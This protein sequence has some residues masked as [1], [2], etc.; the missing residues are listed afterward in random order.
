MCPRSQNSVFSGPNTKTVSFPGPNT[1]TVSFTVLGPKNSVI[2]CPG[3]QNSV[4]SWSHTPKQFLLLVPHTK[5]VSLLVQVPKQ[6]YYWCTDTL[7]VPEGTGCPCGILVGPEGPGCLINPDW[8]LAHPARHVWYARK[9]KPCLSGP[10]RFNTVSCKTV[11]SAD[12][13]VL[14]CVLP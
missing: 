9:C 4:F 1:K 6:C 10:A 5:T 2:Y 14:R 12:R 3:T 8:R 11:F 13:P 7:D